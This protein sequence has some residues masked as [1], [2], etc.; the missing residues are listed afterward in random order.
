MGVRG[1]LKELTTCLCC[2]REIDIVCNLQASMEL[3][4]FILL[5]Y[6]QNN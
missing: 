3:Y 2:W 5:Y 1:E 6:L 4:K